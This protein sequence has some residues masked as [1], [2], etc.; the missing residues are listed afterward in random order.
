MEKKLRFECEF[1]DKGPTRLMYEMSGYPTDKAEILIENQTPVLYC[2]KSAC[3]VLAEVFAK[4][5]IGSY[6]PGFHV[7]L[8]ENF[9][10]DEREMLRVVLVP[11]SSEM[12]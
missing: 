4:L 12:E 3:R 5:A 7:H 10:S 8:K 6:N 11:E 9:D 1:E 2:N